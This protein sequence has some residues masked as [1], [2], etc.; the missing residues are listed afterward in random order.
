MVRRVLYSWRQYQRLFR[1]VF[2]SPR[3]PPRVGRGRRHAFRNGR[4]DPRRSPVGTVTTI[5]LRHAFLASGTEGLATC[6]STLR[7]EPRHDIVICRRIRRSISCTAAAGAIGRQGRHSD[8]AVCC[9]DL[10]R[11]SSL[12]PQY[13]MIK[14]LAPVVGARTVRKRFDKTSALRVSTGLDGK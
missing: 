14:T 2:V 13:S 5:T 8:P 9:V 1:G 6:S 3:S 7:S 12:T 4:H 11:P 10:G